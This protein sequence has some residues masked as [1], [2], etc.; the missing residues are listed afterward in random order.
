MKKLGLKLFIPA[1]LIIL[2]IW[3]LTGFYTLKSDGGEQAVITRFGKWVYTVDEAGLKWHLPYPIESVQIVKCDVVR[4]LELGYRTQQV[5]SGT[6]TST[7]VTVPEESLMITGDENLV[8]T[9][10]VIQYRIKNVKDYLFEVNMPDAALKG[11]AESS[12]RRVVANHQLY[13]VMT[14]QKDAIQNEIKY[15]LQEICEQYRLG[16]DILKVALQAVYPPP[17]VAEAFNDVIKARE[18]MNRYINEAQ[19]QANEIVPAAEAREQEMLNE[20]NAYKEKRIAEAKGDVQNFNQ[21]LA[22]YSLGPEVT[23]IRM[24]LETMQQVLPNARIYIM[25]DGGEMLKFLPI[26]QTDGAASD[27]QQTGGTSGEYAPIVTPADSDMGR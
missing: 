24:Y 22:N 9:E 5:G 21:V 17:E 25:K 20:A 16:V 2:G 6:Q 23:R 1:L 7:F 10:T 27:T 12:V 14:D 4:S 3:L 19:K 11:A 18:D 15:D 8:Y 13:E 26:G